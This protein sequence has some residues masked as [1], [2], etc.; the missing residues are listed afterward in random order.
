MNKNKIIESRKQIAR[1]LALRLCLNG[2]LAE[3]EVGLLLLLLNSLDG[4]L[5]LGKTATDGAGLL[6]AE[7]Q[8]KEVLLLVEETELGTLGLG[9]DGH[10]ASNGL[11]DSGAKEIR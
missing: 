9:D 3:R 11:A 2:V 1:S 7:I 4:G 5:V 8:G 6:D 10:D